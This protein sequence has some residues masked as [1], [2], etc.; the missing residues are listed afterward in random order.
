LDVLAR[1][2]PHWAPASEVWA[3]VEAGEIEGYISAISFNNV[4][5]VIRR[6]SGK[7]AAS[8]ALKVLHSLFRVVPLDERIIR[9]AIDADVADFEDAIQI[10]SA[11]QVKADILLTRDLRHFPASSVSIVTP[12]EFLREVGA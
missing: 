2:E 9:Q 1:R 10:I 8:T 4:H 6:A 5:Y 3:R 11:Q 7:A 12:E